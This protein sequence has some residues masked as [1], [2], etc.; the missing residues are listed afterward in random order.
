MPI[1][2]FRC[3]QCEKQFETL[4]MRSNEVI[5]CPNCGSESLN[6]LISAHAVG[7]GM[8][9]TACGSAPCSSAP[10]SSAP[11]CGGGACGID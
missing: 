6:K 4:V 7:H 1:Y 3:Q 10:L 5:Q 8:P 2:E 9:D 11:C